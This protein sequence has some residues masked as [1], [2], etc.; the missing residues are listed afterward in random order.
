MHSIPEGSVNFHRLLEGFRRQK[1]TLLCKQNSTNILW[2]QDFICSRCTIKWPWMCHLCLWGNSP[3]G[4]WA[5]FKSLLFLLAVFP[6]P[7]VHDLG[8]E[9]LL[10]VQPEIYVWESVWKHQGAAGC[11]AISFLKEISCNAWIQ[12]KA[13][14]RN[15][16]GEVTSA[17]I[18]PVVRS[19]LMYAMGNFKFRLSFIYWGFF[20]QLLS[21]YRNCLHTLLSNLKR[22]GNATACLL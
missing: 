11:E 16:L 8:V 20:Y 14:L 19:R 21:L 15:T 13:F 3:G 10:W 12:F 7:L 18:Y 1:K 6:V 4:K 17:L 2:I 9:V 5:H 22:F